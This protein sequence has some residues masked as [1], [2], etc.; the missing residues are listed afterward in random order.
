[1]RPAEQYFKEIFD[2]DD[3]YPKK[4]CLGREIMVTKKRDMYK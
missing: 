1:M 3:C 4:F 2:F